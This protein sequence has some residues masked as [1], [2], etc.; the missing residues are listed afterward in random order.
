VML[1]IPIT[2]ARSAVSNRRSD[3]GS[4]RAVGEKEPAAFMAERFARSAP[5]C[6]DEAKCARLI[7]IC[8]L[9]R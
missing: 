1:R 2:N 3:N 7:L 4:R 8:D 5:G 6:Q 9:E